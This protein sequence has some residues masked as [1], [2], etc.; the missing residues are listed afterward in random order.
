MPR[1]AQLAIAAAPVL[2][3]MVPGDVTAF[4]EAVWN[5]GRHS[6]NSLLRY[7]LA[8]A[9]YPTVVRQLATLFKDM[10]AKFTATT[11]KTACHKALLIAHSLCA[12]SKAL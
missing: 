2:Q 8:I 9:K 6:D 10:P 4:E 7:V 12:I 5:L 3:H 1:V 11:L